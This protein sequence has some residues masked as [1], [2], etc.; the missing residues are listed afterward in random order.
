[1]FREHFLWYLLGLITADYKTMK[2][3]L[4]GD[5]EVGRGE[6]FGV[7]FERSK[8]WGLQKFDRCEQRGMGDLNFGHFVMT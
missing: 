5:G 8:G 4:R 1:M 7:S 3:G 2:S 6:E